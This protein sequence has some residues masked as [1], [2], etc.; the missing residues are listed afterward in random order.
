MFDPKLLEAR[1]GRTEDVENVRNILRRN[2]LKFE[3]D[4]RS[5]STTD[6][7]PSWKQG[8]AECLERR[9]DGCESRPDRSAGCALEMSDGEP[10]DPR[11]PGQLSLS[12]SQKSATG[13]AHFRGQQ[14]ALFVSH[15]IQ[16][17]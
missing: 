10:G 16:D 3:R 13:P 8:D 5:A 1:R 12:D 7:G 4:I 17:L 15:P 2:I 6:D 11:P 9:S 14:G